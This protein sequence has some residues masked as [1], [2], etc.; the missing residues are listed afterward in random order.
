MTTLDRAQ[1]DK[2][3]QAAHIPADAITTDHTDRYGKGEVAIDFP[4]H[5]DL[6]RFWK[7]LGNHLPH[8]AS[9]KVLTGMRPAGKPALIGRHTGGTIVFPSLRITD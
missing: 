7:V 3:A 5:T 9:A 6:A 1:L 4:T 2:I 8:T